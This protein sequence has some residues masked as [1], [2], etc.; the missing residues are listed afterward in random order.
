[1]QQ[2]ELVARCGIGDHHVDHDGFARL[3]RAAEEG[4]AIV[5]LVGLD[6]VGKAVGGERPPGVAGLAERQAVAERA[7]LVEELAQLQIELGPGLLGAVA[8]DLREREADVVV[9]ADPVA[10][11]MGHA[12]H[13]EDRGLVLGDLLDQDEGVVEGARAPALHDLDPAQLV[14]EGEAVEREGLRPDRRREPVGEDAAGQ[15]AGQGDAG[16]CRPARSGRW[17]QADHG[18][19]HRHLLD[20]RP[21]RRR[22]KTRTSEN[23]ATTP[24]VPRPGRCRSMPRFGR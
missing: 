21:A 5:R 4:D 7:R 13:H 14:A 20:M 17:S 11:A 19:Q 3:D 2:I 16:P 23:G 15:R 9:R 1:L 6:V 24:A 22:V 18:R 12:A 10:E 8:H